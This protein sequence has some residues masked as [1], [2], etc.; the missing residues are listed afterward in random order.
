[1]DDD[2]GPFIPA[3]KRVNSTRKSSINA[4]GFVTSKKAAID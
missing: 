4:V 3:R 2:E 1:M